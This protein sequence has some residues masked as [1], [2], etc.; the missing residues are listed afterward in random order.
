MK[1]K[2]K[3]NLKRSKIPKVI[4]APKTLVEGKFFIGKDG[5][6][7]KGKLPNFIDKNHIK[8]VYHFDYNKKNKILKSIDNLDKHVHGIYS[9]LDLKKGKLVEDGLYTFGW[10]TGASGRFIRH[11]WLFRHFITFDTLD[12]EQVLVNKLVY[13]FLKDGNKDYKPSMKGEVYIGIG[14]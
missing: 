1:L 14:F 4:K 2:F 3:I 5:K 8:K 12:R 7:M 10:F 11:N 6:S 13:F 9:E